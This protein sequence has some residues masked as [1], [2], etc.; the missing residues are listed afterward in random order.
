MGIEV[1]SEAVA[2][3]A[4]N[5]QATLRVGYV[6]IPLKDR[7]DHLLVQSLQHI[8][9]TSTVLEASEFQSGL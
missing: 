6:T 5:D 8:I 7:G 9:R 3:T 1:L 4:Q 2:G